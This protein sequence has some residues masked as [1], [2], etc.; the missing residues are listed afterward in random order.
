MEQKLQ[1]VV[2]TLTKKKKPRVVVLCGAGI[3]T[4]AG[5][6]DFRSPETGLYSNLQKLSLPYAEAV[7]DIEYFRKKPQAFYTLA[8]EL[9]PGKFSPTKF[10][11]FI[12]LLQDKQL[13]KRVY[14]QNIDTL[15][16]IAGV[17]D[18]YIV[19][20]HGSFATNHCIDCRAEMSSEELKRQM[21][22]KASGGIPRCA[23]C[24]GYVKP[25]I[26]F[27]GEGLPAR[28]FDLWDDD[29]EEIDLAI[30]AGTS[31]TV[32]PFASLPAEVE[33]NAI[34]L[35]I[36]KEHCGDFKQNPRKTD[37]LALEDID[38]VAETLARLCGWEDDL[39]R[40]V[41]TT[42]NDDE[43]DTSSNID[44]AKVRSEAIASSITETETKEE[45]KEETEESADIEDLSKQLSGLSGIGKQGKIPKS[46][47]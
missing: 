16:R 45:T 41:E 19:E 29:S 18:E 32:Y 24:K 28:F 33:A 44:E 40:L 14:T 46:D 8:E 6:P 37:V 10:H 34:R 35:L 20:A 42:S 23:K 26:V 38:E 22:D 21:D 1:S 47:Q 17:K 3:S 9:Y 2:N 36:N 11:Y 4:K 25:D 13:L 31:L 15:E 12:R 27:F 43:S 7:F 30:V 5:I 39:R